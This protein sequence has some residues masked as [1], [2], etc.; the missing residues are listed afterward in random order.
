M[1]IVK[2][3]TKFSLLTLLLKYGLKENGS[4]NFPFHLFVSVDGH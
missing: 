4:H 3:Q 1:L 2:N